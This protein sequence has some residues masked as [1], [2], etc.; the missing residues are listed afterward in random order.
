MGAITQVQSKLKIINA[1]FLKIQIPGMGLLPPA[2]YT[3][4]TSYRT[5]TFQGTS[6]AGDYTPMGGL[7]NI[8]EHQRDLSATS[9]DT[10]ISLVGVDQTKIGQVIDSG[11][12]GSKVEIW[13]GFYNDNYTL[14]GDLVKR[15]TGIITS[16]NIS[17]DRVDNNDAFTLTLHCSSFKRVLENRVAG[18]H[19]NSA[20]WKNFYETDVSMDKIATLSNSKFNFGQKV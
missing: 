1:E 12:K 9:Y 4:S 17:E 14:Q 13:R 3:F 8:S 20:S 10:A 2:T 7:V 15:Y 19:T 6:F 16:F 18:R 11:L 5:E